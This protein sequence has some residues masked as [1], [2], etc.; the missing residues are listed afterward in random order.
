LCTGQ[1]IR[2]KNI[3]AALISNSLNHPNFDA[4]SD[5]LDNRTTGGITRIS[6]DLRPDSLRGQIWSLSTLLR[7]DLVIYVGNAELSSPFHQLIH[8]QPI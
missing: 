1:E 8:G 4:I 3:H 5:H 7:L 6:Q 2:K